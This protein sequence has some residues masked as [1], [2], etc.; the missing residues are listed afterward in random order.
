VPPLGSPV[1]CP[2]THNAAWFSEDASPGSGVDLTARLSASSE[3]PYNDFLEQGLEFTLGTAWHGI[4]E[5]LHVKPKVIAE[6]DFESKWGK[7]RETIERP[8]VMFYEFTPTPTAL[9]AHC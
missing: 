4:N 6:K 3:T 9:V 8:Q 5:L 1:P 7:K 2:S